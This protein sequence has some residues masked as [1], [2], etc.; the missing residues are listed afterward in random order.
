MSQLNRVLQGML[1]GIC[2]LMSVGCSYEQ[3]LKVE[4]ITL[5]AADQSPI[6]HGVVILRDDSIELGRCEIGK[7]GK[8]LV[9]GKFINA[10]YRIDANGTYWLD[11]TDIVLHLEV[12]GKN[13]ELPCPRAV[14]DKSGHNFY[15]FVIAAIDTER[16]DRAE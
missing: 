12:D 6:T 1:V 8:W 9:Q 13:V 11:E 2:T 15:A 14:G 4:G 5:H 3:L 7:D 10:S 16:T